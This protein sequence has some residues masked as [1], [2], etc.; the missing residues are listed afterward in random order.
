MADDDKPI[1]AELIKHLTK[2][3]EVL[4]TNVIT[5]R[6]RAAFTVWIGPI[7][8]LGALVVRQNARGITISPEPRLLAAFGILFGLYMFLAYVSGRIERY[9]ANKCNEWRKLIALVASGAT[10]D[11][12]TLEPLQDPQLPANVR[13]TYFGLFAAMFFSFVAIVA[14]IYQLGVLSGTVTPVQGASSA[15]SLP[16]AA[17]NR[18]P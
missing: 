17:P 11:L 6:L 15:V 9:V 5:T 7:V 2:E 10:L 4:S 14:I 1:R 3:I 12:K 18:T 8:L 13:L 16:A